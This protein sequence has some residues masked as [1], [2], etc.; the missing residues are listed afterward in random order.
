MVV[1]RF[2]IPFDDRLSELITKHKKEFRIRYFKKLNG[3]NPGWSIPIEFKSQ[4]EF[5]SL[6]ESKNDVLDE[7]KQ[8]HCI[9]APPPPSPSFANKQTQTEWHQVDQQQRIYTRDIADEVKTFFAKFM[10]EK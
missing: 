7:E 5:L 9:P 2:H 10:D 3:D 1:Q 6:K 4:F 8:N